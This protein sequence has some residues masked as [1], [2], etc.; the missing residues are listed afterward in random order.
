VNGGVAGGCK[1]RL[2]SFPH[3]SPLFTLF[4]SSF[5]RRKVFLRPFPPS[6]SA[7]SL[8]LPFPP[9]HPPRPFPPL[10]ST[11]LRSPK[12]PVLASFRL[13]FSA[14]SLLGLTPSS[15]FL[16][17][18]LPD[19]LFLP[20]PK[21]SCYLAL[22]KY[23]TPDAIAVLQQQL[24]RAASTLRS[25]AVVRISPSFALIHAFN[26]M[27]AAADRPVAASDLT[28][29]QVDLSFD[30]RC[31]GGKRLKEV[32]FG[33]GALC[34]GNGAIHDRD[35]RLCLVH[36]QGLLGHVWQDDS[37]MAEVMRSKGLDLQA[38]AQ[39]CLPSSL[40]LLVPFPSSSS[41]IYP[42]LLVFSLRPFFFL[43]FPSCCS[44]PALAIIVG[45]SVIKA[46]TAR[47]VS[48]EVMG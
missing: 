4:S 9:C 1:V 5:P 8:H 22:L 23:L 35:G 17:F 43:A 45:T 38:A 15:L 48:M 28:V 32:A 13:V 7:A 39:I 30:E 18:P 14:S 36:F 11:I 42:L 41:L 40:S 29:F 44:T 6:S 19:L 37:Y 2:L 47:V 24:N 33:E 20:D 46:Q 26:S 16:S 21:T 10:V 31:T 25:P 12:S 3:S 34:Q 27:P